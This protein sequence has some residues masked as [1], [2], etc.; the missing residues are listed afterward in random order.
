MILVTFSPKIEELAIKKEAV[1]M[2]EKQDEIEAM[3][4]SELQVSQETKE[5][6]SNMFRIYYSIH[7][8]F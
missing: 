7:Q 1:R 4:N 8:C 5:T 2:L 6:V 3:N